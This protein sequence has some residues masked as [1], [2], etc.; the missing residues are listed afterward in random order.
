MEN[1]GFTLPSYAKINWTLRVLGR[2]GDGFHELCTVFQTVSLFDEITF[3]AGDRIQ[4]TSSSTAVPADET[5]LIARAARLLQSEFGVRDG[6]TIHLEKR[7]PAPGGLGGGSSNAAVALLGLSV[8]WRLEIRPETL[9]DLAAR[10][11]SDVPFFLFGGTARAS[12]RGTKLSRMPEIEARHM[13]VVTPAVEV[14][15]PAAFARL[16]APRLTKNSLKSILKLCQSE[17]ESFDW[18]QSAPINDFEPT[19]FQTEPEIARVKETLLSAGARCAL[20]SGSGASVYAVFDKEETRQATLK[21]LDK[22]ST[23]RKFAVATV[24]RND[25]REALKQCEGLLPISF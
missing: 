24:S 5:N 13:I 20:L 11:G 25:Y 1:D 10:L 4:L 23:W 19:V 8:L 6:A 9:L 17:A 15:T 21:A 18:R 7:I 12:G 16:N 3:R 2:R 14:A 22:E